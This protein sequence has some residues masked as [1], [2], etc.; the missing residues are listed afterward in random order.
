MDLND[1]RSGVTLV[2]L[3]L[4]VVLVLHTWSRR[5]RTDHQAA[6][7]LPF[8]GDMAETAAAAAQGERRE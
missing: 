1:I 6:A 8:E 4:F 3:V 7:A 2:S 5:R